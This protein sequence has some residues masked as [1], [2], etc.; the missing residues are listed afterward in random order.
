MRK[1]LIGV[2]CA[3]LGLSFASCH[4]ATDDIGERFIVNLAGANE[5]PARSTGASG[6]IGFNVIGNRV[7]Y[8]IEVHGMSAGITGAHLH[9]GAAGINGPIRI[10]LFPGPGANFTTNPLSGVDGQLYEGSF[11]AADVTGIS[12]ADLLAGMRAGT[13]YGNVHT[14][15]FPGGEIRGQAQLLP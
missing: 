13:V 11:E 14:S 12:F 7:D 8:S 3:L 10:A 1:A 6:V 4:K 5:V 2:A 9:S 15:N